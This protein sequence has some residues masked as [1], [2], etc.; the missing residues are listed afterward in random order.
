MA[1]FSFKDIFKA[2]INP[3][4]VKIKTEMKVI[5][6]KV[7]SISGIYRGA[8]TSF[9]DFPTTTTIRNNDWAILS[10][11]DGSHESGI[12]IYNKPTSTWQFVQDLTNF[13]EII[14]EI[15][16]SDAEFN[17]GTITTKAP[18]VKQVNDALDALAGLISG[19]FLDLSDVIPATAVDLT[20]ATFNPTQNEITIKQVVDDYIGDDPNYVANK[21]RAISLEVALE[22]IR[23]AITISAYNTRVG[24]ASVQASINT[25]KLLA[26]AVPTGAVMN[27]AALTNPMSSDATLDVGTSS[28]AASTA[29]E[30]QITAINSGTPVAD[31]KLVTYGAFRRFL[32]HFYRTVGTA[33]QQTRIWATAK[34]ALK[35]G[36]ATQAFNVKPAEAN[37]TEAINA[38]QMNFTITQAEANAQWDN[39]PV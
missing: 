37:T 32:N 14:A 28:D 8:F 35:N 26:S 29:V 36:D 12:Y 18:T 39:I 9:T 3:Y 34:F 21:E 19:G 16:S 31:D 10:V 13:N 27:S 33:I 1:Q 7:G 2:N 22:F 6:D 25:A 11:D 5:D 15:L 23:I 38:N 20:N 24:I 30:A 17:T 4:L